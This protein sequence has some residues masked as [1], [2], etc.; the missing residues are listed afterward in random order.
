M[1]NCLSSSCCSVGLFRQQDQKLLGLGWRFQFFEKGQL[2]VQIVCGCCAFGGHRGACLLSALIDCGTVIAPV[3][4]C[5]RA[6]R[7]GDHCRAKRRQ[8]AL[9][10]L[11]AQ[12]RAVGA[13]PPHPESRRQRPQRSLRYLEQSEFQHVNEIKMGSRKKKVRS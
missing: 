5:N 13:P 4:E 9:S 11:L 6:S 2:A 1:A 12:T 10:G 8:C 7:T 3:R